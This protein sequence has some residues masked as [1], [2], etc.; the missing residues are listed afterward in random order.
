MEQKH[1]QP[2]NKQGNSGSKMPKSSSCSVGTYHWW[3]S[4]GDDLSVQWALLGGFPSSC[5]RPQI[6]LFQTMIR[7]AG[8]LIY[9]LSP[10]IFSLSTLSLVLLWLFILSTFQHILFPLL[11]GFPR[12]YQ[13]PQSHLFSRHWSDMLALILH[14][15]VHFLHFPCLHFH[16]I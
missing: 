9:T 5:Q 7:H 15:H 11:D 16:F 8:R 13:P 3:F 6:N 14:F 12:S 1:C 4:E 2:T 10:S